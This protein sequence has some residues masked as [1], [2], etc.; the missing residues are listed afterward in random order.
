M[1]KYLEDVEENEV[2]CLKNS[3][4]RYVLWSDCNCEPMY[5]NLT[6][7]TIYHDF[8][9]ETQLDGEF[10]EGDEESVKVKVIGKLEIKVNK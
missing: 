9:P 1:Y 4:D 3:K 5:I 6:T 7:K 10:Y 8:S 2:F